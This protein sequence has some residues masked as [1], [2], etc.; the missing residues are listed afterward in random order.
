MRIACLHTAQ[1]NVAVFDRA[2]QAF[3]LSLRHSVRPDL[4][5][6]AEA[7]GGLTTDI[8]ARTLD[9]LRAL[10]RLADA[11]VLTCST[12]GPAT[13]RA[14]D[15][16]I[17]PVVRADAALAGAAVATG[18]RVVVLCT[19]PT[20]IASTCAAFEAA[21]QAIAVRVE[22]LLVADAW[23]AFKTGDRERY[24]RLVADVADRAFA[25]GCEVVALAQASMADA[26][27]LCR[28]GRPMTAPA[29]ALM[30]A[31]DSGS[32]LRLKARGS[33]DEA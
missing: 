4:L 21:A 12:L 27:P 3:D 17:R 18:A 31:V 14:E 15:F 28:H 1:T 6:D 9:A 2:A 10:D 24:H 32:V 20:T 25:S 22:M 26:A 16:G 5:A 13:R 30:A 8:E 19:A 29:A 33:K 7:A 11:T 23:R